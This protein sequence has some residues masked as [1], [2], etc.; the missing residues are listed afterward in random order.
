M[1]R[2]AKGQ[3]VTIQAND[4]QLGAQKGGHGLLF[5]VDVSTRSEKQSHAV[6]RTIAALD[7]IKIPRETIQTQ[8][9][10]LGIAFEAQGANQKKR[11]RPGGGPGKNRPTPGAQWWLKVSALE[12]ARQRFPFQISRV[13]LDLNEL[14]LERFLQWGASRGESLPYQLVWALPQVM[15]QEHLAWQRQAIRQLQA[16]GSSGFQIGHIAQ[17][18]LF[19]QAAQGNVEIFGDYSCNLLNSSALLQYQ[20]A[21]LSGVQ[22][23]L[24]TDRETLQQALSSRLN[25][26]E[27]RSGEQ[28]QVGMY[29]YGRPPLFS[30]F[31]CAAFS[32]AEKLCQQQRGAVLHRSP[33]RGSLCLCAPEFFFAGLYRRTFPNGS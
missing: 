17:L 19:D 10:A 14:N 31:E 4:I 6:K 8:L 1:E 29:V 3:Q 30:A 16:G 20:D 13:V 33:P 23:F 12:H 11:S 18:A 28:V 15:E 32:G 22:F 7:E 21:G 5:R 26:A 25:Q 2:A 27:N 9:R 24:E